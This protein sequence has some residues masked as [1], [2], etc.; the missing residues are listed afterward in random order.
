MASFEEKVENNINYCH[1]LD[2]VVSYYELRNSSY[3][4]YYVSFMTILLMPT[5]TYP[6]D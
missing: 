1:V 6:L 3:T 2:F 5:Q 4:Q